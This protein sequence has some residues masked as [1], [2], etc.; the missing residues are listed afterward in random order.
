MLGEC[1]VYG[2]GVDK[3]YSKAKEYLEIAIKNGSSTAK[4]KQIRFEEITKE[5]S[6]NLLFK[7]REFYN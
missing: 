6:D 7:Y 1:Y 4:Q 3:N 5:D 2:W